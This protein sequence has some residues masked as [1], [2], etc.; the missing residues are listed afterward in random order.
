MATLRSC[1]RRGSS[2]Y[3]SNLPNNDNNNNNNNNNDNGYYYYY[4]Y[5]DFIRSTSTRWL[6]AY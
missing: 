1:D 6:F 4:Y 3:N 2:N 5:N